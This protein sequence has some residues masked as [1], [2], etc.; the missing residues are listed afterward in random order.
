MVKKVN[1]TDQSNIVPA[2]KHLVTCVASNRFFLSPEEKNNS[3][4]KF[5]QVMNAI[6]DEIS[7]TGN[8][9][10]ISTEFMNKQLDYVLK[11]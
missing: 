8:E 1:T 11:R 10:H 5:V 7:Q 9:T 6:V 2:I 3:D 4:A